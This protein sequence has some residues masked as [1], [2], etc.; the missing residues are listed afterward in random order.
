LTFSH[1]RGTDT[2]LLD[3]LRAS[4]LDAGAGNEAS[5]E[6]A[7]Q[8]VVGTYNGWLVVLSV[9]VAVVASFVALEMAS[10]VAA[11]RKRTAAWLWTIGGAI[12]IGA[13]IWSM[14]FVGMLALTLP[15]PIS[16]DIAITAASLL[17]AIVVSGFG[18]LEARRPAS[19]RSRIV[20][21]GAFVGL[22][23]VAMHYTGM[24]AMKM[25]PPI[26]YEPALVG[27][28][29]FIAVAG[30]VAGIWSSVRLRMQTFFSALVNKSGSALMTG[31]AI[32]GMHYAGM[33]AA[34]FAP[35]SVCTVRA[36]NIDNFGLAAAVAGFFLSF[37]LMSLIISAL[38]AYR[39]EQASKQAAS[40]RQ[41]NTDLELARRELETRVSER[42]SELSRVR[43]KVV[44]A[45]E[46]ERRRLSR[47]LHDRVGQNLTVLGINLDILRTQGSSEGSAE[48]RSRL[49]D[50]MRLVE[51]TA[52]AIENV[53]AELRP[54]MLD[55]HGLLPALQWYARQF[56]QRTGI[57]VTVR[58]EEPRRRLGPQIEITLFR[59]AQEALNNVAK[60]AHAAHVDVVLEQ[61]GS[62]YVL[63]LSDDGTGFDPLA[64]SGPGHGI[65][66]MRERARSV[67]GTFE[68]RGAPGQGTHI[69]VRIA[70]E[71]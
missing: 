22:G 68:V 37:Q 4:A 29:I 14:H 61:S 18:L 39:A 49:E 53:M 42:T 46:S 7:N 9:V 25:E 32:S 57:D 38:Y 28:S 54:P 63:S 36:Q 67:G 47:E 26:R 31:T 64:P 60:H 30:S 3:N 11:A 52:D 56:S 66:I 24:A 10:Q 51:A 48:L 58:G 23:I 43:D 16:F 15:T 59:I 13:G 62:E 71:R 8:T 33:A 20:V 65:A 40:L 50:S 12:T 45:Q 35:N 44:E 55:D 5:D 21:S 2:R 17:L 34:R 69:T 70:F 6:G 27:L 1:E 41:A 19:S